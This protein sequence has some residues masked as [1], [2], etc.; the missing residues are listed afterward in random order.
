[1]L[2]TNISISASC[3][4]N[5]F[6]FVFTSEVCESKDNLKICSWNLNVQKINL[7]FLHVIL[8]Y[9]VF[10]WVTY[11]L[12]KDN[13][14][15][16]YILCWNNIRIFVRFWCIGFPIYIYFKRVQS[17]S[18]YTIRK[19]DRWEYVHLSLFLYYFWRC[20]LLINDRYY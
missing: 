11:K 18:I 14:I 2:E 12:F 4:R 9:V 6:E 16:M 17:I 19:G 13:A 1:M 5:L 20:S 10:D 7:P 3:V 15:P 8:F